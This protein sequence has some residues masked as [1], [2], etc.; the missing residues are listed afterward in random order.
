MHYAD[1]GRPLIPLILGIDVRPFQAPQCYL[2]PV[3]DN[4][5]PLLALI[6]YLNT[7]SCRLPRRYNGM[8]STFCQAQRG[9]GMLCLDQHWVT[10]RMLVR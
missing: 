8:T 3:L 1:T 5:C 6:A 7:H 4:V 10:M 9:G 2:R